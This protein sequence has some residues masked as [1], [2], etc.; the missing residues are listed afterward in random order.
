[1]DLLN[2]FGNK[3]HEFIWGICTVLICAMGSRKVVY[4]WS[5]A[6]VPFLSFLYTAA[7]YLMMFALH[8]YGLG[9]VLTVYTH[10]QGTSK[11]IKRIALSVLGASLLQS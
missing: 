3:Q 8:P 10:D 6:Q 2:Y 5:L 1:M 11:R 9:A 7:S 4:F